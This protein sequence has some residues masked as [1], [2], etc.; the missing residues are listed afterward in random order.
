VPVTLNNAKPKLLEYEKYFAEWG[1]VVGYVKIS[2]VLAASDL[3]ALRDAAWRYKFVLTTAD[4]LVIGGY[5]KKYDPKNISHP[6]L[7]SYAGPMQADVVCAG[8]LEYFFGK[9]HIL[10]CSGHYKP[11]F[12]CLRLVQAKLTA[13]GVVSTKS[14]QNGF[15]HWLIKAR[16]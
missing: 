6:A 14:K 7:A 10:N 13:L 3:M 16:G 8:Y 12:E 2:Q 5:L 15:W 4:E 1:R 9:I 11:D